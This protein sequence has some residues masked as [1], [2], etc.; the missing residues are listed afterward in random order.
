MHQSSQLASRILC[1]VKGWKKEKSGLSPTTPQ[2]SV[3][4]SYPASTQG[5]KGSYWWLST[6]MYF[7]TQNISTFSLHFAS[8]GFLAGQ[9]WVLFC[10][11][12][13]LSYLVITFFPDSTKKE[14][15]IKIL[16]ER[17]QERERTEE[18]GSMDSGAWS[19]RTWAQ[20]LIGS[21]SWAIRFRSYVRETIPQTRQEPQCFQLSPRSV[22][23][24]QDIRGN[25]GPLHC[26]TVPLRFKA[27]ASTHQGIH[28][29]SE[30]LHGL[31]KTSQEPP[32]HQSWMRP[33]EPYC[34][35]NVENRVQAVKRQQCPRVSQ[36]QS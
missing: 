36:W 24:G 22:C 6:S 19:W 5:A 20:M 12:E 1:G 25:A 8:P 11:P 13:A 31:A 9:E 15:K 27:M 32:K 26:M 4:Q 3:P 29:P 17:Y 18:E 30:K 21:Q 7:T 34:L 33:L 23:L 2:I 10:N 14:M 28:F 16:S 35:T